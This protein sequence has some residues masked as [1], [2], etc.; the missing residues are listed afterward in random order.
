M[1]KHIGSQNR[2]KIEETEYE[3]FH[4]E[5]EYAILKDKE[6]GKLE[7]W[8]ANDHHAG[9]TIEINGIGYEFASSS[10]SVHK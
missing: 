10:I 7:A 8:F 5:N 4:I 1:I 9:Y 6:T 3:V 2:E